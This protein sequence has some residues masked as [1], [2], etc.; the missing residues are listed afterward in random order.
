MRSAFIS[1]RSAHGTEDTAMLLNDLGM[2]Y[3]KEGEDRKAADTLI[4]RLRLREDP[5]E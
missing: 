5:R 1:A 3:L 4:R 2:R